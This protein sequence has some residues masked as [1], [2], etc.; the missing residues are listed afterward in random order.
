MGLD[1][2]G[3]FDIGI[4]EVVLRQIHME[5]CKAELQ[6]NRHT[7]YESE[8]G[9]RCGKTLPEWYR[10]SSDWQWMS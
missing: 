2:L 4:V 5:I 10:M 9:R 7:K 3:S 8:R 6:L 1:P